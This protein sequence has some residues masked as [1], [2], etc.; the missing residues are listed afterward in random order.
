MDDMAPAGSLP[1][2][3]RYSCSTGPSAWRWNAGPARSGDLGDRA[4]QDVGGRVGRERWEVDRDRRGRGG[5][6]GRVVEVEEEHAA[7]PGPVIGGVAVGAG[8]LGRDVLGTAN[9]VLA[10][11]KA[12]HAVATG[13]AA[14]AVCARV[15]HPAEL[16]RPD[17][18]LAV[19]LREHH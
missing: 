14:V 12:G 13:V 1:L 2:Q 15:D 8:E 17:G 3:K 6:G 4:Q 19:A 10:T 9:P 16:G 18:G 7:Q 11:A 5:A